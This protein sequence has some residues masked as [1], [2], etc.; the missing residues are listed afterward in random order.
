MN[1]FSVEQKS[2]QRY[3]IVVDGVDIS[4][5]VSHFVY[6]SQ[7][8][9]L[10]RLILEGYGTGTIAEQTGV[11]IERVHDRAALVEFLMN[12]DPELLEKKAMGRLGMEGDTDTPV[13]AILKT[14]MEMASGN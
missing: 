4:E 6:D 13:A 11:A 5:H 7:V 9:E 3:E 14:L 12:V 10:P 2:L 8:G 1:K